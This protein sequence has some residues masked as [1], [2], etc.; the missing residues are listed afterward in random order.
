MI[1]FFE[2]SWFYWIHVMILEK[3]SSCLWKLELGFLTNGLISPLPKALGP[4][5]KEF[6]VVQVFSCQA[7]KILHHR[8][9]YFQIL[10]HFWQSYECLFLENWKRNLQKS[11][12]WCDFRHVI[13][14]ESTFFGALK[15]KCF[16]SCLTK[17]KKWSHLKS[18]N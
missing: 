13:Y 18:S 14:K 12:F 8:S 7:H 4:N 10:G 6:W 1:L 17:F 3:M 2:I 11:Y 15:L 5:L 16:W 9:S